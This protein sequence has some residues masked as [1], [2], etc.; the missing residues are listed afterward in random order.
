MVAPGVAL[1]SRGEPQITLMDVDNHPLLLLYPLKRALPEPVD[2]AFAGQGLPP[3]AAQE[4]HNMLTLVAL[5]LGDP[6]K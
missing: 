2:R 4:V 6:I 1:A 3:R 5:Y